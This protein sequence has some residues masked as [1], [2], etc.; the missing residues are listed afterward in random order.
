MRMESQFQ[1]TRAETNN[2]LKISDNN[3]ITWVAIVKA[4]F[5]FFIS[6]SLEI[7]LLGVK[8]LKC[9]IKIL[10]LPIYVRV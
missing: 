9:S 10:N 3:K 4:F 6:A 2:L 7:L 5:R 1:Y 8:V